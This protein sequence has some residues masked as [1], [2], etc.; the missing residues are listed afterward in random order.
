[1]QNK[2][3]TR[4]FHCALT[5]F[6]LATS[7]GSLRAGDEAAQSL[8]Q[9]TQKYCV[10]CHGAKDAESEFRLDTLQLS[11]TRRD[12]FVAWQQV[13]DRLESAEMPPKD[14]GQPSKGDRLAI[15]DALKSALKTASKSISREQVVLRR[16]N[17][18]QYR[19]TIRDLLKVDVE[20]RDPTGAFPADDVVDGFDNIG[21]GLMMSD[22]LLKEYLI[23]ARLALDAVPVDGP[24]PDTQTFRMADR[25]T[26][27]K[28][29]RGRFVSKYDPV[30]DD[31][32]FLY[33]NDERAPGDAR[34]QTFDFSQRVPHDGTYEFSFE[35][36]SKG[37]GKFADKFGV[38]DPPDYQVYS[39]DE[40]H[41][42]EIYIVTP[43]AG[44][45]PVRR[46]VEAIDLPDDKRV[47]LVRRFFLLK[48]CQVQLAFGNGPI[49]TNT[50]PYP[51]RLGYHFSDHPDGHAD[52]KN[53]G[54]VLR[55]THELLKQ[56]DVPR[57]VV[58]D[59]AERGP[60]F[61]HWPPL[62]RT[63]VYGKTGQSDEGVIRTFAAR[64]FR[65]PVTD[66]DVAPFL[67]VAAAKPEGVRTAI[68]AILCS[69]Q[70]L[71]LYEND[72]PLDDYA[73]A[74][75]LSYFLWNTMPDA[76]L[77]KL[78]SQRK[79]REPNVLLEQTERMLSDPKSG[80]FVA[81]FVGQWLK[82]QNMRDMAPDPTK[83][84]DFYRRRLGDAMVKESEMFF[85]HLLDENLPVDDFINADFTFLNA[86]LARHYGIP[87]V[88]KTKLHKVRL[89][90]NAHRGG[91]LGQ[92]V[93]VQRL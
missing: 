46:L 39:P 77:M 85:R 66:D 75:R 81:T 34:G 79:L 1:M 55:K 69:P 41:R 36:E 9:F 80:E 21:S 28:V 38:G 61:E 45:S 7:G 78:A 74:S 76:T 6:V 44:T 71:Y 87:G 49:A 13:L 4:S 73:I 25:K 88:V 32:L 10:D 3:W 47:S 48:G 90:P 93:L 37:R 50:V 89:V 64:A 56:I 20:L 60:L 40:L 16:L 24:K 68:E 29:M 11:L 82:L 5:L 51:L 92:G 84:N 2:G 18:R 33:I 31:V 83:F 72:G 35:V 27:G 52:G 17:R 86:A 19:N 65:R 57:I 91:L 26:G 63:A 58:Y 59:A 42:L 15:M 14:A 70:F 67:K 54:Q 43:Q 8:R 62:G 22:F 23:A 30:L 53:R 12:D